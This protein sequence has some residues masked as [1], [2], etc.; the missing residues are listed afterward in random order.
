MKYNGLLLGLWR[1][2]SETC[3]VLAPG[4]PEYLTKHHPFVKQLEEHKIDLLVPRYHGT[5]ESDGLFDVNSSTNSVEDAIRFAKS[6]TGVE[7]FNST[8]LNWNYKKIFLVGF[9]YGAIPALLS[10][11]PVDKTFLI[12]PF[13]N[14]I[15][16]KDDIGEDITKTFAFLEKAYPYVYRFDFSKLIMELNNLEYPQEK[17]LVVIIGLKDKSIP[18]S[19]IDWI[20]SRYSSRV[21]EMDAGHTLFLPK[22]FFEEVAKND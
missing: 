13:V 8:K 18:K 7:L 17:N 22:D 1:N 2:N 4:V 20:V 5:W 3:V 19:E 15:F 10:C 16:H 6:G 21:M 12:C 14:P 11:E 9:S